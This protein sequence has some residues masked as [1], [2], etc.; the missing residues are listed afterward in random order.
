MKV[1]FCGKVFPEARRRLAEL[2]PAVGHELIECE[3]SE[4]I[5]YVDDVDVIIPAI[6]KIDSNILGR[7]K[8]GLVQQ[9][10]VG[11][12][13]VDIEAA[14]RFGVWVA[15]V[16]SSKLGNAA[17]VAELAMYLMMGLSRKQ[18]EIYRSFK[19]RQVGQPMGMSLLNKTA[20]IVGM[21][22]V[23][24]AL[25]P[26]LH[27]CGMRLTAVVDRPDREIPT[28]AAIE[29][30]YPLSGIKDAIA[31]ADYIVLCINYHAGLHNLIN[32][33]VLQSTKHGTFLVNVARGGLIN[34]DDLV[35]ALRSGHLAGA[36]IDVF[37]EE[38]VNP[39]HPLFSENVIATPHIAG[40]TDA[41]YDGNAAVCV[42]NITRYGIGEV[43]LYTA[44]RPVNPRRL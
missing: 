36:G 35:E 43:P 44:N 6:T 17:S 14:T 37:W 28:E 4:I 15:R 26:R 5:K 8:F 23:G 1:L 29:R 27:A 25:A 20:C 16:P 30:V 32:R 41:S 12:D 9:F 2:L 24:K 42:E 3:E 21:G 13:T 33:D 11:L 18:T 34:P 10:G 40:V 7:G 31:D 22:N 38:P 19:S 39:D